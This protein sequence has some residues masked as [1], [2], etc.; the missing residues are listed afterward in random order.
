VDPLSYAVRSAIREE[1]NDLLAEGGYMRGA[2]RTEVD[3]ALRSW[4]GQ[5]AKSRL[6]QPRPAR[7]SRPAD[8]ED[9]GEAVHKASSAAAPV[10]H[11][12]KF[13]ESVTAAAARHTD[14]RSEKLGILAGNGMMRKVHDLWDWWESLEEPPRM[15]CLARLVASRGFE[16][17][18]CVTIFFNCAFMSYSTDVEIQNPNKIAMSVLIGDWLFQVLY[19]VEMVLKLSVH[20]QWFFCNANWKINI[21]DLLLT[22]AGFIT[23]SIGAG[24]GG[25]LR[26][27]RMLRFGKAIHAIRAMA[28]LKHLRALI[29]CLRGSVH[30]LFWSLV[31]LFTVY[32]LFSLVLLQVITVHLIETDQILEE[33]NF[34]EFFGSVEKSILTLYKASTGGDDWSLAYQV[35]QPTGDIGSVTYLFFIAFVHF[36][37]INIITGIFVESAMATL[38]PDSQTLA[39]EHTRQELENAQKLDSLCRDV[40]ADDSGKLSRA[41]FEDCIK[42]RHMTMLLEMMGLQKHHVLEFFNHLALVYDDGGQVEIAK[43]VNGCMLLK[44]AATNFDLQKLHAEFLA[45]QARFDQN[46]SRILK[47]LHAR[48]DE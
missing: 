27:L 36:A 24:S 6:S 35:I 15:G 29:V 42:K 25:Y 19:T 30:S 7:P 11:L 12:A 2:M 17:A 43:F 38:T 39:R 33:S 41:E 16:L 45:A 23:L 1:L 37:L 31:L 4:G 32:A 44:G 47:L 18:V 13:I 3:A 28:Q 40:D 21:F 34:Y 8:P 20:Q 14:Y 22:G 10:D 26:S 48:L 9:A 46:Q 5:E